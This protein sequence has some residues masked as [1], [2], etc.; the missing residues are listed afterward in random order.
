MR[1]FVPR[2]GTLLTFRRSDGLRIEIIVHLSIIALRALFGFSHK[3][4]L[5]IR[6]LAAQFE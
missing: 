3:L 4:G 1:D 5:Y 6:E 2:C